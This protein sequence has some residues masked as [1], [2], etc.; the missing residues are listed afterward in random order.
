M[1][2]SAQILPGAGRW[3]REALA[4]GA[5]LRAQA[6]VCSRAPTTTLRAVPLPVPGRI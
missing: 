5:R 6:C 4:E 2:V 3:Q 1:V